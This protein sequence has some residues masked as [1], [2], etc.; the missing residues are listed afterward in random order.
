MSK[1]CNTLFIGNVNFLEMATDNST[2]KSTLMNSNDSSL[3]HNKKYWKCL[4]Y[5]YNPWKRKAYRFLQS[6]GQWDS[7]ISNLSWLMIPRDTYL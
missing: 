4:E 7:V 5:K 6:P 1:D 2:K 3:I